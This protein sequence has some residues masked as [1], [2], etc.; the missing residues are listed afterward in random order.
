MSV[1]SCPKEI[2]TP[3]YV[4]FTD[5]DGSLLDHDTY[6]WAEASEAL[7]LC[8]RLGV[9]VVMVSSKTAAE[10]TVFAEEMTLS[11][12]FISENGGGIFVPEGAFSRPP[13]GTVYQ[14]GF[15]KYAL[16]TPYAKLVSALH[17]IREEL[18]WNIRGF[19]DMD[20][21]EIS[22]LTGLGRGEA[23]LAARR[24]FDEPF[25]ILGQ[26]RPDVESLIRASRKRG[27]QVAAG[28]RFFHLHGASD[29]GLA[30]EKVIG[31]YR[32]SG[33]DVSAVA[34]GDS[35]NDFPMLERAVYPVLIRSRRAFPELKQ[36]IPKLIVTDQIGPKGW[37]Q[38]VLDILSYR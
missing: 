33:R 31:W 34:L 29:K 13:D 21:S 15:W 28:G 30:M 8:R 24:D 12:P 22:R 36:K 25:V 11:S 32:A 14:N 26:P 16:G 4:I 27:L 10:L 5:L 37:N 2:P 18:G 9:P 6:S 35:P 23:H 7:S 3:Y 19:S 1:E 38:A 17:Q 20:V